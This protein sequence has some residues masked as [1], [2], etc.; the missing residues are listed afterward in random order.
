MLILFL[1]EETELD[2]HLTS[3]PSRNTSYENK[4]SNVCH[5][6]SSSSDLCAL[7][8]NPRQRFVDCDKFMSYTPQ[9]RTDAMRRLGRCFTCLAPMHRNPKGCL[10]RRR[11]DNWTRSHHTLLACV[12]QATNSKPTDKAQSD[13]S[14]S[15]SFVSNEQLSV[16]TACSTD[17]CE[18]AQRYSPATFVEILGSSGVWHKALALFDTGS[19]VTLIKR[20]TVNMLK[21]HREPLKLKFGS[22]EGGYRCENYATVS[23]RIGSCYKKYMRFNISAFELDKPV[24]QIPGIGSDFFKKHTYLKSVEQCVPKE[25]SNVDILIGFENASLMTPTKCLK[26]P[27]KPDECPT[28]VETKFGWYIFGPRCENP[29][30]STPSVHYFR[31]HNEPP[32]MRS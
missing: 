15:S 17:Q 28:A 11:C 30:P 5:L 7:C 9:Q 31:L 32:D 10:Y 27:S 29:V 25:P 1:Q 2:E 23:L 6:R 20:S 19:D 22:A 26:H 14:C 8:E 13:Q 4:S 24:H 21:L 12:P 18:A 3:K 16:P